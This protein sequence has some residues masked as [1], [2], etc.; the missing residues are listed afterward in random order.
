MVI[1]FLIKRN[2]LVKLSENPTA[3]LMKN[4]RALP[5][6]NGFL[7]SNGNYYESV[8]DATTEV[9]PK[10]KGNVITFPGEIIPRE[11]V[12]GYPVLYIGKGIFINEKY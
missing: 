11:L 12:G 2:T 8:G 10:F 4:C 3:I 6:G 9:F 1:P 7:T 5:N